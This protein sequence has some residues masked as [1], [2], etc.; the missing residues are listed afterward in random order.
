MRAS[1]RTLLSCPARDWEG[2]SMR[3][4]GPLPSVVGALSVGRRSEGETRAFLVAAVS[5][6]DSDAVSVST[7]VSG[8]AG[9]SALVLVLDLG[10]ASVLAIP[11]TA[12]MGS[13]LSTATPTMG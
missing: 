13:I 5:D 7:V 12:I 11:S 10:S 4:S 6:A 1:E 9:D 2:L 8:S 3:I